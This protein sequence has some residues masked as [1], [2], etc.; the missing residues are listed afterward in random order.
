MRPEGLA[1]ARKFLEVEEC[2]GRG[3]GFCGEGFE[4]D[5]SGSGDAL[6]GE[7]DMGGF[8]S[9]ATLLLWGEIGSIGLNHE[10]SLSGFPGAL[11]DFGSF[12]I[13]G[14]SG[15]RNAVSLLNQRARF[16]PRVDETMEL[17]SKTISEF[18]HHL[19]GFCVTVTLMDDDV[20]SETGG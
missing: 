12:G 5:V 2:P 4:A 14:N 10:C 3:G 16:F 13:G 15:K 19:H 1:S 11:E 9:L 20:F 7:A 6:C 17:G 8:A 18:S